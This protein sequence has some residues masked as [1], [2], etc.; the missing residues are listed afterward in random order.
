ME[1]GWAKLPRAL[2]RLIDL[3]GLDRYG[4]ACW[5]VSHAAYAPAD[6]PGW[7]RLEPGQLVA[8]Y[9]GLAQAWGVGLQ[10][11][12]DI[13]ADLSRVGAVSVGTVKHGRNGGMLLTIDNTF[14]NTFNNTFLKDTQHSNNKEVMTTQDNPLQHISQPF[15]QHI[16]TPRARA[17][18][19][20]SERIFK[21][22][23]PAHGAGL[24][25][26]FGDLKTAPEILALGK[27]AKEP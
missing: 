14:S 18:N 3:C 10:A 9:R 17:Y 22:S 16:S 8:T 4:A 25:G 20:G 7:G 13:L 5:L 26:D 11:A 27:G 12:R 6:L 19:T 24:Y 1:Q 15:S 23:T 21:R 2:T